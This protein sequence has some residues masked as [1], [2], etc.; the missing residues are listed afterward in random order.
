MNNGI[1][2]IEGSQVALPLPHLASKV[3]VLKK[4]NQRLF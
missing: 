1:G 3:L 2:R 4:F